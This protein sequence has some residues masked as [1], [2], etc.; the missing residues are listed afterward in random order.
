MLIQAINGQ[1][2][3]SADDNQCVTCSK[4][5]ADKKCSKCKMVNY[6]DPSCQRLHWFS[7]KKQCAKLEGKLITIMLKYVYINIE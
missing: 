6:C 1:R 4:F 2:M 5:K 7:H 3:A